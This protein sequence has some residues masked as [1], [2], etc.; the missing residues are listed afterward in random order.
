HRALAA[1]ETLL[2][3]A[4][5][6]LIDRTVAA[7]SDSPAASLAIATGRGPIAEPPEV[8]GI[9]RP[10][11]V[12]KHAEPPPEERAAQ[13]H[14]PQPIDSDPLR[15]LQDDDDYPD[16]TP[17]L[18]SSPVGSGGPIGRLLKKLLGDTRSRQGGPPG[19]EAPTRWSPRAARAA[20]IAQLTTAS[21]MP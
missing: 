5:C 1:Q 8:F 16:E 7:R 11:H 14:A 10:G 6:S 20:R 15:D 12:R 4:V 18:V 3:S 13:Q 21:A 9:I 19:A 2:P 17:D